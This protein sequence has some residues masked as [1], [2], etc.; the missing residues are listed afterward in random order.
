VVWS[1]GEV[2]T[3]TVPASKDGYGV[4][5]H[6][7]VLS[8]GDTKQRAKALA[9]ELGGVRERG[10][11][12]L[13][14][15]AGK[16]A[17]L[18]VGEQT[19]RVELDELAPELAQ[20]DCD[21]E[22][23]QAPLAPTSRVEFTFSPAQRAVFDQRIRERDKTSFELSVRWHDGLVPVT[24]RAHIRGQ[25]SLDCTRKSFAVDLE[26][27]AERP[28]LPGLSSDE[29]FLISM[30]LDEAYINQTTGDR[31][32]RELGLFPFELKIVEL[33]VDGKTQGIYLMLP[34]PSDGLERKVGPLLASVIRRNIDIDD[35]PAE[36]DFARD[37]ETQALADYDQLV[38][39]LEALSGE[40]LL[41]EARSRMDLDQFLRWIALMTLL[42]NGDYV[43]ELFF[44]ASDRASGEGSVAPYFSVFG[45]DP[46]DL[47]STCHHGGRFAITDPHGLLYCAEGLLEH[48]LLADPLVYA[49]YVDVLEQVLGHITEQRFAATLEQS[50]QDALTMLARD[51]LRA[52]CA[53]LFGS[54]PERATREGAEAFV[55]AAAAQLRKDFAAQRAL[56]LQRITEYR[57]P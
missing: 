41:E 43:D 54:H 49:H 42:R 4:S 23:A 11:Y 28:F 38:A 2:G 30:C 8:G 33:V 45:W 17:E 32:S 48:R 47:F 25:S 40:A 27:G 56:L 18:S 13:A 12:G 55:R 31:L 20:G 51:D 21:L 52:A 46:D 22:R 24:A 34:Q 29:F 57:A 19:H 50:T 37:D 5:L 15:C 10:Y 16:Q 3:L 7:L 6:G 14:A 39:S 44:Y 53:E 9:A 1:P 35:K 36:L 26:G